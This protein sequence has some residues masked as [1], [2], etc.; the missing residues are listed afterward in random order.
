[1]GV[2]IGATL[3]FAM[4]AAFAVVFAAS[5]RI[6]VLEFGRFVLLAVAMFGLWGWCRKRHLDP[7][8][9]DG[10]L[11]VGAGTLALMTCGIISN[12]GL[13][14]GAPTIDTVLVAADG[15]VGIDVEGA[16]RAFAAHPWLVEILGHAYNI[17]GPAAVALI[18]WTLVR[19]NRVLTW[20]LVGTVVVSMQVVGVVSIALPAI[21]AMAHLGMLD[22]QG[23]GLPRGAGIYH[24]EAFAHFHRGH[25][26]LLRL[27]D[28]SGLVTFPSFHTVLALLATQ[29]LAG[30]A[31]RW[32]GVSWTA[33]VIASTIPIGGH[34]VTDLA[35]GFAIWAGCAW[36]ARRVSSPSA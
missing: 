12:A 14:L 9:A 24:L 25:E 36:L 16:V 29:A 3:A 33:T 21:G 31:L 13:R 15:L 27:S 20:E 18:A 8:L 4:A 34:Y 17:S 26:P 7:R 5:M 22:L 11:I 1:M 32:V 30:T 35:A 6:D 19:G 28:M 10:A 2:L 23:N